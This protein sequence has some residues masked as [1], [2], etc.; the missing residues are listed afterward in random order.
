M[1]EGRFG[2]GT[3]INPGT[4]DPTYDLD[5][6]TAG[7]T[8]FRIRSGDSHDSLIRFDQTSTNQAVMGYDHS[9]T[10]FKINNHSS[11]GGQNHLVIN[12][13]GNVGLGVTAPDAALSLTGDIIAIEG[14]FGVIIVSSNAEVKGCNGAGVNDRLHLNADAG[15]DIWLCTILAYRPENRKQQ[16]TLGN[17]S[18][19]NDGARRQTSCSRSHFRYSPCIKNYKIQ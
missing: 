5:V 10:L 18:Y 4:T 1:T 3:A 19:Y 2:V 11:F 6:L 15:G 14:S 7:V 9:L 13:D 17:W 16:Q 8:T 12:T